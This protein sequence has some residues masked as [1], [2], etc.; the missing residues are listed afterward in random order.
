MN[1]LYTGVDLV[2]I[3]RLRDLSPAVYQRFLKRV[4]SAR[5]QNHQPL[6]FSHVAGV[7]AAKEAVSKALQCGIGAVGWQ[8]IE[9]VSDERGAP[10][11]FLSGPALQIAQDL[12]ICCWTVSISHEK[13]YAVAMVIAQAENR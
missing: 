7:F 13:E 2:E 5:E 10:Q 9:I 3:K 4:L 6:S 8:S 11:V 1:R 12:F